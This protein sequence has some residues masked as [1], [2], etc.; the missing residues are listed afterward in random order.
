MESY[1]NGLGDRFGVIA[2]RAFHPT[3]SN[4]L[5]TNGSDGRFAKERAAN[6]S[7]EECATGKNI[8]KL[9]LFPTAKG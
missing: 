6:L 9:L 3:P 8:E 2:C 1:C 5:E 4:L 7:V